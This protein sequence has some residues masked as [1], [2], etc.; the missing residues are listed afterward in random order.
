MVYVDE[1]GDEVQVDSSSALAAAIQLATTRHTRIIQMCVREANHVTTTQQAQAQAQSQQ[2]DEQWER[3]AEEN[4]PVV[5]VQATPSEPASLVLESPAAKDSSAATNAA[6]KIDFSNPLVAGAFGSSTSSSVSVPVASPSIAAS[7]PSASGWSVFNIFGLAS[8]QANTT[9]A[10]KGE[11]VTAPIAPI[12]SLPV[13]ATPLPVSNP[14]QSDSLSSSTSSHSSASLSSSAFLALSSTDRS[15]WD[16]QS[17]PSSQVD[18]VNPFVAA[19]D[20]QFAL[21]AAGRNPMELTAAEQGQLDAS[22][23][24]A[25]VL[26]HVFNAMLTRAEQHIDIESSDSTLMPQRGFFLRDPHF[27]LLESLRGIDMAAFNNVINDFVAVC[28]KHIEK[29]EEEEMEQTEEAKLA[30]V[31]ASMEAAQAADERM[32]AEFARQAAE[33]SVIAQSLMAAH[34]QRSGS[35]LPVDAAR[36]EEEASARL[37]HQAEQLALEARAIKMAKLQERMEAEEEKMRQVKREIEREAEQLAHAAGAGASSPNVLLIPSSL[38][39]DAAASPVFVPLVPIP[40]ATPLHGPAQSAAD[41]F[42][43]ALSELRAMG[44][45]DDALNTHM[46]QKTNLDMG[47]TLDWL[48]ADQAT[49]GALKAEL[50]L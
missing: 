34:E 5:G 18:G 25:N 14:S 20:A 1:D 48:M 19:M 7:S 45:T 44:F 37:D 50:K 38:S 2:E 3:I 13:A 41:R 23:V 15:F 28:A 8:T 9:T 40:V 49:Q 46:L 10:A 47:Q 26:A 16:S 21:T 6:P 33:S 12:T 22:E 27:S 24:T 39:L 31:A 36:A 4:S 35:R 11:T 17:N 30:Q 29:R 42:N 32:A 43:A